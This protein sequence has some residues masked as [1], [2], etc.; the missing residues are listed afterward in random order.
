MKRLAAVF[1][2]AAGAASADNVLVNGGF[3]SDVSGWTSPPDAFATWVASDATG[4]PTS[5]SAQVTSIAGQGGTITG[6]YQCVAAVP[7]TSYDFGA[8]ARVDA[9]TGVTAFVMLSFFSGAG[10]AGTELSRSSSDSPPIGSWDLVGGKGATAP[11]GAASMRLLLAVQK[12]AAGGQATALFDDA[13]L[14]VPF[15]TAVIPASASIHG[16][17]GSFFHTDV[18]LLNRSAANALTV[19]ARFVC[20]FSQTCPRTTRPVVLA[21][22]ASLEL[23]DAVGVFFGAP[24]TAGA[25]ELMWDPTVGNLTATS[26]TYTPSLPAPTFGTAVPALDASQAR[27]RAV[28]LGLGNNGG[29]LTSGFRSNAGVYNATDAP[30]SVTFT[31]YGSDGVLRGSAVTL[32]LAAREPRQINDVFAAAGAGSVVATDAYLV[33]SSTSPVYP[34]VTVIDNKSGD[35]VFVPASDDEAP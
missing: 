10:C 27:T 14:N 8:R 18:W 2:L 1:L 9:A 11:D 26:R 22:R 15:V 16:Q 20:Y 21:P 3:A 23:P 4:S 6:L 7:G 17:N 30:V 19:T 29:D 32:S 5:G 25:I 31:L 33:V 35:S 13:Y 24:E 34:Y 12:A 28:F